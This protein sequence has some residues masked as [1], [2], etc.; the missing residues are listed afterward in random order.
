[1]SPPDRARRPFQQG[2]PASAVIR[3]AAHS[4]GTRE[5]V[6]EPP[7]RRDAGIR[8]RIPVARSCILTVSAGAWL[9]TCDFR[10]MPV[11][12]RAT[13]HAVGINGEHERPAG[14][15]PVRT[16]LSGRRRRR[17]HVPGQ[18]RRARFSVDIRPSER[19][20]ALWFS[21]VRVGVRSGDRPLRA[22]LAARRRALEHAFAIDLPRRSDV[23]IRRHKPLEALW[24]PTVKGRA[25]P[26]G[27]A[28]SG[29]ENGR[30]GQ[31]KPCA[32]RR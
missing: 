2:L 17:G 27:N 19:L 15:Q 32:C 23:D 5:G 12:S 1:M 10:R 14:R 3:G 25:W 20:A 16:R 28:G 29:T 24:F 21:T 9:P 18:A 8:V 22:W 30:R 7:V 26:E 13:R 11:L 31:S 4:N 6:T